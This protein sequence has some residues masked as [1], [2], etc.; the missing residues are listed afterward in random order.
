MAHVKNCDIVLAIVM[1]KLTKIRSG[2]QQKL[3]EGMARWPPR[4][5]M[6]GTSAALRWTKVQVL[7]IKFGIAPSEI[8]ASS[9]PRAG[10][11]SWTT[12][13]RT[14]YSRWQVDAGKTRRVEEGLGAPSPK[15]KVSTWVKFLVWK[16]V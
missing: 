14:R 2:W 7:V 16:V 1:N 3:V 5:E 4:A 11:G 12:Q 6:S 13:K 8:N 9:D 15:R 10:M